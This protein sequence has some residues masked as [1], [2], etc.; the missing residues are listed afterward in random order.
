[1]SWGRLHLSFPSS[2]YRRI[3]EEQKET[4]W[5]RDLLLSSP[6]TVSQVTRVTACF[7]GAGLLHT[8][9]W[10]DCQTEGGD[11][12]RNPQRTRDVLMASVI[13]PAP[14]GARRKWCRV[15]E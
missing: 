5:N 10:A 9:R 6:V 7:L 14:D 1:M 4:G 12:Q 2:T 3:S 8:S 11:T 13:I 15:H